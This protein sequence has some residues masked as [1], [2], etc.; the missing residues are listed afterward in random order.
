[1]RA[2]FCVRMLFAKCTVSSL[3]RTTSFLLKRGINTS[4]ARCNIT[5]RYSPNAL[6][7]KTLLDKYVE[8]PMPDCVSLAEYI[9]IDGT[10]ANVRSKTRTLDFI[11]RCV[12]ELPVWMYDGSSTY[13]AHTENSDVFLCP[14]AMYNNPFHLGQNKLV[15]CDT[16]AF[17]HK[18]TKTNNRFA[19]QEVIDCIADLDPWFGIEQE[20][21]LLDV[22]RRPFG[23]PSFGNPAP[24]GPYYCGVGS[25]YVIGRE[26]SE[27]HYRACLYAGVQLGGTNA[28]VLLSQWEFQVG[29]GLGMKCAD[30]LWM[31]RFLLYRI[32]EEFGVIVTMD[33]KPI[34]DWNG[35]GAHCNFSTKAMR[36]DGGIKIIEQCIE[37][38]SK[39]QMEHIT[40]YD[41]RGG[42]D[43]K[44]RL[45]GKYETA[46]YDKFTS[47]VGN[48]SVSVRI[49]RGVADAK[50]GYLEDRRPSAN[51][52]PYSVCEMIVRTCILD[53]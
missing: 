40:R 47:G 11:P 44:R 19:C 41:P 20:Y 24:Q 9:W 6:T 31:A 43:N 4:K 52:D 50:K 34:P 46:T 23:W 26:I 45:T 30:D 25:N 38:L 35:S 5:L 29:P 37:K 10:G 13:Q 14:R 15:L 8:L 48:R 32:A 2:V 39:K 3:L 16:Y 42:E 33:P 17:D 21:V 28:E 49:P 18:P 53:K 51:A 27:A 7:N 12:E 36:E 22:D 1:M